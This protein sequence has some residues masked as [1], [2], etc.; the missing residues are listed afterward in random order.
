MKL[1]HEPS[2]DKLY[3]LSHPLFTF[4]NPAI[5]RSKAR[6]VELRLD[7]MG[8][9]IINPLSIIP[10]NTPEPIATEKCDCL[11]MACDGIIMCK[12]WRKSKGCLHERSF[13]EK[14]ELEIIEVEDQYERI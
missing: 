5:N 11:L 10:P 14:L 12:N 13:A 4:G 1:S 2:K 8:I 6:L 9:Y 3:F 7:N